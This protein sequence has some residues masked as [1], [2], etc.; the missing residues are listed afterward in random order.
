MLL[1]TNH[2]ETMGP[3]LFA[4]PHIRALLVDDQEDDF[5]LTRELIADIEDQLLD[6]QWE[7][8]Y[9]AALERLLREQFDILLIDYRLGARTGIE[10]LREAQSRGCRAPAILLTGHGSLAVERDALQAGITTYIPKSSVTSDL[11]GRSIRY[12]VDQAQM[13]ERLRVSERFIH[14]ILDSLAAHIAVIDADG[15]IVEVNDAWRDFGRENGF[16]AAH[17]GVG[18]NYLAVCHGAAEVGDIEAAVI[19]AGMQ[20]VLRGE[21]DEFVSE[22]PCHSPDQERWFS[23]HVTRTVVG[24]GFGAVVAHQDITRRVQVTQALFNAERRYRKLVEQIPAMIYLC[25][26]DDTTAAV[27]SSPQRFDILGFTAFEWTSDPHFWITQLHPDDRERVL[28]AASVSNETGEPFECEYRSIA[29]DGRV[30]WLRDQ[31]MLIRDEAGAPLYWQGI[32]VDITDRV[33]M[34][35]ALRQREQEFRALVD[36][37]PDM[38]SRLDRDMRHQYVNPAVTAATGLQPED[39]IG[40]TNHD[41]G[42]AEEIVAFWQG[43]VQRVFDSG[44]PVDMEYSFPSPDGTRWFGSRLVPEYAPTGEVKYVLNVARDITALKQAENSARQS[45]QRYRALLEHFPNGLVVLFDHDLRFMIAEGS[46]LRLLVEDGREIVEQSLWEA[47]SEAEAA[48]LEPIYRSALAGVPQTYELRRKGHDL[49]VSVVPVRD[50]DG[51]VF[52]GMV[53]AIDITERKALEAELEHRAFH[54][55]LTG[56]PNRALLR[57]RIGQALMLARRQPGGVALLFLDIDNF[58]VINDS[59]GHAEGD[60]LLVQLATRLK[61]C[62]RETDTISRFGGDEFAILLASVTGIEDAIDVAERIEQALQ[63]PFAIAG[64]DLLV[65]SSIGIVLSLDGDDTPDD[66][67]RQADVAMYRAKT[68]GRN[69][70]AVFDAHMHAAAVHRLELEEDLRAAI[71]REELRAY[72]QPKMSLVTGEVVGLEALVRWEHPTR[73]LISPADF[74][75]LA[76]E[77]GLILPLGE[78]MLREACR[79]CRE[80]SALYRGP[81]PFAISVNL[82]ARQFQQPDL[83]TRVE[84]LLRE[85]GLDPQL[86]AFEITETVVMDDAES[87]VERLRTLKALGV[88]LAI[89]DFGTGYSSLAYLKRFPID[90]LKIDR[91]FINGLGSSR[92]DTAIVGATVNLAHALDLLVVAEGV[93]TPQQLNLL[94]NFGCD[95][96]QGYFFSAPLPPEAIPALLA[97]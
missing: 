53:M 80:W 64:R 15:V 68:G 55:E 18:L 19:A 83:V 60:K 38:V 32:Q 40:K 52:A 59:L 3:G 2:Y 78:W 91:S 6:L 61:S 75:P 57:D 1:T 92:E 93:E 95:R 35:E 44:Q 4:P 73:G 51:A 21:Q 41:L 54:D 14:G 29:R 67:L 10:L 89:D 25:L 22:Y 72:F 8:T 7:A 62:V 76:E 12:A 66:L 65:T 85:T 96:A 90:V 48:R 42:M 36:H 46:A 70:F 27:Y 82:S 88:R 28:A 45:E 26:V 34:M 63:R 5:V 86:L 39:F 69:R 37:S 77:T 58:K 81:E 43:H 13:L 30:V 49:L 97:G 50:D 23:V 56:L 16:A 9:D 17:A 24:S 94:R 79:R 20:R 11:L 87:T 74:I 47:L 33:E 31:A 84:R 71:D